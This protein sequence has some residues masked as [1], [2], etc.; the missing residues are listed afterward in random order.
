[1][2]WLEGLQDEVKAQPVRVLDVVLVG[3]LM[4]A[5]GRAWYRSNPWAGLALGVLGVA[6]MVYNAGNYARIAKASP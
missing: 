1:L 3:P 4:V 6:T 5:G 2:F